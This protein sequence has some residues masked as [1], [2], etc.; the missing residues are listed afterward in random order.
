MTQTAPSRRAQHPGPDAPSS[1]RQHSHAARPGRGRH[2]TLRG[3]GY[4]F[5]VGWTIA[6][7]LLPGSGLVAAGRRVIGWM[8]VAVTVGLGVGA[9]VYYL[10]SGKALRAKGTYTFA[11]TAPTSVSY[12]MSVVQ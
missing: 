9:A 8:L 11:V 6:G 5:L 12:V 3:Q 1:R 2:A 4:A 10:R 7:T